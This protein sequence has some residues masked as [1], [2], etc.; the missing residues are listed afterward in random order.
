LR[1]DCTRRMDG[2]QHTPSSRTNAQPSVY[3][4]SSEPDSS[5]REC[6]PHLV[7][8]SAQD[9]EMMVDQGIHTGLWD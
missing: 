8:C 4:C 2:E 7:K 3:F 1:G 5:S 9:L 6:A